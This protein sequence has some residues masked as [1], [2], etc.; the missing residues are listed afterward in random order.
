MYTFKQ[1]SSVNKNLS[2]WHK[3]YNQYEVKYILQWVL[4]I[5][6]GNKNTLFWILH[7]GLRLDKRHTYNLLKY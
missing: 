1:F 5:D 2:D 3:G 4:I 7:S 6:K